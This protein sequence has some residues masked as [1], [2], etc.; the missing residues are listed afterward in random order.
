VGEGDWEAQAKAAQLLFIKEQKQ[1][2]ET[3]H[4]LTMENDALRFR[5]ARYEALLIRIF[6]DTSQMM[7]IYEDR[8]E[9]E[10]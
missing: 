1:L 7:Q 9:R 10:E 3:I 5:A 8:F 2:I 6:E 4:R